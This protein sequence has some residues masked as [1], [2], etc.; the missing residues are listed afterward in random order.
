MGA[1]WYS[2]VLGR[3]LSPDTIVPDPKNPQSLNRYS[4]VNNRPLN[5]TDPSGHRPC[6][7]DLCSPPPNIHRILRSVR[8]SASFRPPLSGIDD[9]VQHDDYRQ[10][11]HPA[12]DYDDAPSTIVR[13][14]ANGV[15]IIADAC[16]EQDCVGQG[17]AGRARRRTGSA[18]N[19]GYGNVMVIEY[20]YDSLPAAVVGDI[21]LQEGQSLYMLY[22]HL[23]DA[24]ALQ[25]GDI[26]GPGQLLG[27]I[28]STGH[29]TG[30]HLHFEARKG[31]TGS[32]DFGDMCTATCDAPTPN[33]PYPRFDA[34]YR[35]GRFEHFDPATL[36]YYTAR[37]LRVM[38]P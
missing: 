19:G 8:P 16:L 3:W 6:E 26:V 38:Q 15:V 22:A 17:E 32:L 5:F 11:N 12:I 29:S 27:D 35:S 31:A 34:W 33:D 10:A 24:P 20:P 2:P 1:R 36:H 9:R 37:E 25:S 21:G 4:Y 13:A 23:R 14:S 7:D 28:G 30:P 18:Y